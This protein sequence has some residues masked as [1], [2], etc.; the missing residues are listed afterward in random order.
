[1]GYWNLSFNIRI[2]H[3]NTSSLLVSGQ[4]QS[5]QRIS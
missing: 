5:N 2:Q 1:M 4:L 3:N